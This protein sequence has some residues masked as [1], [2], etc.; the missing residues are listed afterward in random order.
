VTIPFLGWGAEFVDYDNDGWLDIL[1]ANGHVYPQ[2]DR[3]SA[4]TS[5]QQRTLLFRNLGNLKFDDVSGNL[6]QGFTRPKSSRGAAV[7]DLFNEGG[8]DIV[9]LNV[10]DAPTILRN[11]G[12][13]KAGH[14]ISLRLVGDPSRN[15]PREAIGTIVFCDAGGGRQKGE[16]ASGRSYVSQSDL[17]VHF[18]LGSA[19]RVDRLEIQWANADLET[20]PIPAVDRMFTVVQGK[21]I[22]P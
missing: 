12:A 9:L 15:T 20:V 8:M 13:K 3:H 16:V 10:D 6:G 5:Y 11:R 22:Q 19:T 18:G 21:G 17:R 14:W 2:V 7:G 1:A 4:F